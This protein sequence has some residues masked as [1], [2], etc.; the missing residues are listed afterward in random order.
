MKPCTLLDRRVKR[1]Y[2]P[3]VAVD[4]EDVLIISKRNHATT[5]DSNRCIT[6]TTVRNSIPTFSQRFWSV[7]I[8]RGSTFF[9]I[10]QASTLGNLNLGQASFQGGLDSYSCSKLN[11]VNNELQVPATRSSPRSGVKMESTPSTFNNT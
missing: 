11:K 10:I 2:V 5:E 6:S 7:M 4:S 3:T 8:M 9:D 1:R